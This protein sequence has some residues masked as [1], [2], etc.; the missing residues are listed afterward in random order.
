MSKPWEDMNH[1][2]RVEARNSAFQ[3]AAIEVASEIEDRLSQ[4]E[5]RTF[6]DCSICYDDV[7][8]FEEIDDDDDTYTL[9]VV[10]EMIE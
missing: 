6:N 10:K 2:E 1:E 3:D 7:D 8:L 4:F 5:T 9:Q